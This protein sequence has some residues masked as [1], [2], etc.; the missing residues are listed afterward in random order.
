MFLFEKRYDALETSPF[1]GDNKNQLNGTCQLGQLILQGYQQELQNGKFLRDAYVYNKLS[2]D[3][4]A[5]MRL[6]DSK[7]ENTFQDVYYRV[8]DDERTLMSGQI[9]LRGLLGSELHQFF[10]E[11]STEATAGF[12]IEAARSFND[13]Q[14]LKLKINVTTKC[15]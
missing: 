10:Q 8:D 12:I 7:Q 9:V 1:G 3:P 15:F 4:P 11:S 14:K 2:Q 5:S 13:A 6:M